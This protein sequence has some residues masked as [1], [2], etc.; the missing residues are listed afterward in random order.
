MVDATDHAHA[1]WDLI[2][3]EDKHY[4]RVA[5]LETLIERWVHDLERRG[6]AVPEA[7]G[8][9]LPALRSSAPDLE[10]WV[11]TLATASPSPS[12]ASPSPS[13]ASG[14]RDWPTSATPTSGP[15]RSTAP[16]ASPRSR[17]P[18]PG[19]HASTSGVAVA[20]VFTRGP[21]L[22]AM[23]HRRARRGRRR[24]LHDRARRLERSRSSSA[25]TASPTSSP[26]QRTRDVLRFVQAR[27][28]RR[29]DRRGLRDLRGPRLQASRAR[30]PQPPADP[31]RRAAPGRCCAWPATR[32]TAPSS[33]GS[34]PSDVAQCRAE[35]G[36]G[37]TIAARLFVVPDRRRRHRAL[38]RAP[39]DLVVPDGAAPT[40]SSTAGSGAA[41]RSQP[42][43]DGVGRGRPQAGQRG[44]PRRTWSTS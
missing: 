32:P 15:P 33:T 9:R 18:P 42:M 10:H 4:A 25:G 35:V 19:S 23:T 24:A 31:A 12:T 6:V 5:V 8:G 38:H 41:R 27:P 13:T 22:L 30:S 3:G 28:R 34:R 44:H 21:G 7:H 40:P 14:S 29:E 16:T 2:S 1:H 37:K 36:E 43:W 20:P 26:T 17:W 11:M 39:H